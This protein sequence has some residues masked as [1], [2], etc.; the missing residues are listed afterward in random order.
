M[1]CVEPPRP[2]RLRH[3]AH[4]R[5]T[6]ERPQHPQT[7]MSHVPG[8]TGRVSPGRAPTGC[9]PPHPQQRSDFIAERDRASLE[10]WWT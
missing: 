3:S 10:V 9:V 1:P 6:Q 7:P 4:V 5:C 2:P 8:S